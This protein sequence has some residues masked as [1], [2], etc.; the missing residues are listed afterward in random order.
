M[1]VERGLLGLITWLWIFVA[2]LVRGLA[3]MRRLPAEAT[4]DR[5][6]VLGSLAAVVTCLV[7]GLFEY[8]FG[9][10]EV[11][12]VA[13]ALMAQPFALARDRAGVRA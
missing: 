9:D 3:L 12:L 13:L 2:F 5:G 11:Q 4:V 1:L 6:L 8:N 7:G 10:T